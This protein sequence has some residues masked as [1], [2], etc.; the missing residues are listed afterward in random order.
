[1]FF[2]ERHLSLDLFLP[3]CFLTTLLNIGWDGLWYWTR[4]LTKVFLFRCQRVRIFLCNLDEMP[5]WL[6]R[7]VQYLWRP[8]AWEVIQR[9]CMCPVLPLTLF[10][11]P[12][13]RCWLNWTRHLILGAA[14]HH[15]WMMNF[16]VS[17]HI[18]NSISAWTAKPH[19]LWQ[20]VTKCGT[21]PKLVVVVTVAPSRLVRGVSCHG[22]LRTDTLN[23]HFS[24]SL[25]L[26][27]ERWR[28]RLMTHTVHRVSL[29]PD[30]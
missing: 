10:S 28:H 5:W 13:G 24:V 17:W 26:Q 25:A 29:W 30:R 8:K 21:G 4:V 22:H 19:I 7:L 23:Y 6:L 18:L 20:L 3:W 14:F 27:G 1:M 15:V 12:K 9:L 16:G 2:R 11:A